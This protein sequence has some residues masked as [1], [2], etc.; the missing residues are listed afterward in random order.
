MCYGCWNVGADSDQFMVEVH[1]GGIFVG[2]GS[3]RAYIDETVDW[4]DFC[5]VDTWSPLWFEDFVEQ[6]HY[7][8]SY[9]LKIYCCYLERICQMV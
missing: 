1:H 7:E 5:E 2:Q 6:L 9:S 3:N 8:V 4:F